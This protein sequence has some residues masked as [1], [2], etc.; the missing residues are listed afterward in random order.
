MRVLY[1][2]FLVLTIVVGAPFTPAA[3]L[4]YPPRGRL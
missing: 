4:H 1:I 3:P 2:I